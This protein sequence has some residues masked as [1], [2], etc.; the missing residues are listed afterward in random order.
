[1]SVGLVGGRRDGGLRPDD[2]RRCTSTGGGIEV[3]AVGFDRERLLQFEGVRRV[4]HPELEP[5]EDGGKGDDGFLPG[6]GTTLVCVTIKRV[7]T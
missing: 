6:K 7:T 2:E 4:V 3:E 1:M 5:L